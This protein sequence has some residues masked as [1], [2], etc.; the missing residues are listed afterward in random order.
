MNQPKLLIAIL[1]SGVCAAGCAHKPTPEEIKAKSEQ[2]A[3]NGRSRFYEELSQRNVTWYVPGQTSTGFNA[4]TG[5]P[6]QPVSTLPPDMRGADFV[7]A[8][9]DA[10]LEYMRDN[11]PI[12]GS[13]FPWEND[14]FH[15]ASFWTARGDQQ[16]QTLRP[17][18]PVTSP[19]GQYTLTLQGSGTPQILVQS[20]AGQK[21]SP[22][23]AGAS[24][25]TADVLFG[26]SGSDLAFTRWPGGEPV[27]AAMNL[28]DGHWVVVQHGGR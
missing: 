8:H 6:E 4:E 18:Q 26:P 23:P 27:Y 15:Q 3:G 25:P 16:P 5:L 13:F 17:G 11:G 9:N 28:R 21:Q 12:P 19:G 1:L 10:V 2:A 22:A 14:L 20:D 7:K 24:E